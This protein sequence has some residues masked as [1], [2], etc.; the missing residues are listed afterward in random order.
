MIVKDEN[1]YVTIEEAD[2][3][4]ELHYMLESIG[5]Y[6]LSLEDIQKEQLLIQSAGEMQNLPVLGV[7]LFIQQPLQFPRR[8]NFN[9]I[10]QYETPEEVKRAQVLNAVRI[11]EVKLML[12]G[13]DGKILSSLD[14]E[15][16]MHRWIGGG[17]KFGGGR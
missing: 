17:F 16:E 10:T 9:R 4:V 6:W 3:I 2:E 11:L 1:S 7:K 13:K 15:N 8:A 5:D 12:K 14:A